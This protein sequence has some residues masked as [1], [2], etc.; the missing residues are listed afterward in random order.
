MYIQVLSKKQD[1][2]ATVRDPSSDLAKIARKG[3]PSVLAYRQKRDLNKCREKFWEIE[4]SKIGGL[5]G[6]NI[7]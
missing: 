2:V 6:T 1:A 3:C 5:M 7:S 4:G